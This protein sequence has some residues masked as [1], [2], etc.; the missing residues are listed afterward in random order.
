MLQ[1]GKCWFDRQ[2]SPRPS[3]PARRRLARSANRLSEDRRSEKT[4]NERSAVREELVDRV[5]QEI[6]AGTYDTLMKIEAAVD[7]LLV[8]MDH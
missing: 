3:R 4:R 5:R 7:R 8:Q 2:R 6:K 1:P